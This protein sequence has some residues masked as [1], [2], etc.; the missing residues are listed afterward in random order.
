MMMLMACDYPL[1]LESDAMDTLS[2][3]AVGKQQAAIKIA[4]QRRRIQS[5]WCSKGRIRK[6]QAD[7]Q[8]SP[9]GGVSEMFFCVRVGK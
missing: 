5:S 9:S 6:G 7:N 2:Y 8:N 1:A 3:H 4:L